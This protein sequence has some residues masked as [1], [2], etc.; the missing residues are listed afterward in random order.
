MIMEKPD[1]LFQQRVQA[2]GNDGLV[3]AGYREVGGFEISSEYL[4]NV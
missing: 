4:L 1:R 3:A 2:R